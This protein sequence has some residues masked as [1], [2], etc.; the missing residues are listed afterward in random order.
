MAYPSLEVLEKGLSAL[1]DEINP[2]KEDILNRKRKQISVCSDD[3][4]W[5]DGEANLIDEERVI[6]RLQCALDYKKEL[7]LLDNAGKMIVERLRSYAG[8]MVVA[9]TRMCILLTI[10]HT[11]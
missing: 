9:V 5:L 4:Q 8:D 1:K 3:E 2:R 10:Y 11:N 6:E 7:K